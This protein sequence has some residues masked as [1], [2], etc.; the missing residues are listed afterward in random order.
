MA[1]LVK[2]MKDAFSLYKTG[3]KD[4]LGTFMRKEIKRLVDDKI[5]QLDLAGKD[6]DEVFEKPISQIEQMQAQ[7]DRSLAQ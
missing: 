6:G 3:F 7:I 2:T 4:Q 1:V 5:T